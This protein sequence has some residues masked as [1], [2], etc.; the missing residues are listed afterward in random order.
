MTSRKEYKKGGKEVEERGG[1]RRR[2]RR[3]IEGSL[4]QLGR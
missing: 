3:G 4:L 2:R 1:R